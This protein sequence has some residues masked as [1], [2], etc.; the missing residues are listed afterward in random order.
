MYLK[1]IDPIDAS[2]KVCDEGRHAASKTRGGR[3]RCTRQPHV[4]QRR[5]FRHVVEIMNSIWLARCQ[6]FQ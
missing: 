6:R 1:L 5:R 4:V 2:I 3:R